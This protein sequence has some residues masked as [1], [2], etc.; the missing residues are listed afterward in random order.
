MTVLIVI[1]TS[2]EVRSTEVST[3][4]TFVGKSTA[5]NYD[6]ERGI[7]SYGET[8]DNSREISPSSEIKG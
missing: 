6:Q 1:R 3:V 4:C 7:T 8:A 2:T 5:F